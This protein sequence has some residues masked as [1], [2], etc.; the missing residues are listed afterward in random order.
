MRIGVLA[1]EGCLA[2]E[3]F[4]F[5]DLLRIANRVARETG[6]AT[7]DPFRV[8]VIAASAEPVS[9][10]GGFPIGVRRWHHRFD[11]VIVP[12]FE[13]VPSEDVAA[14]LHSLQ[15]ETTFLRVSADRGT[16]VASVCVGAFL[17]GE[18]G[19]LDGRRATTSWLFA[20]RL[21]RRYPRATVCPEALIVTDGTVTTTAAFSAALDLATALVREH[22]GDD[23]A[24]ATARITLVAENRTSQAPYI[25]DSMLPS[26]RG[27]FA[28]EVAAW[29]VEHLAEPYDLGRLADAF[30]V[31]TRTLLRRFR[32]ETGESPL[33]FLRRAR[34][35]A[36]RNLLETTDLPLARVIERVGYRDAGTFR[37]LFVEQVGMNPAD[38]RRKFHGDASSVAM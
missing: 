19:L 30:H 37:R 28:D 14:R 6:A 31:S 15:R 9:A 17:L 27:P 34:V 7:E 4:V 18:A 33:E 25:V 38:Y 22:L 21:G 8:S 16:R 10:A 12:G 32:A 36:A 26:V 23:I 2:A 29:L 35:R 13:L 24:R 20:S 5:T 1:Y 11:R 3:I